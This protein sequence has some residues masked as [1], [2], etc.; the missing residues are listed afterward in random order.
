MRLHC[1]S[2]Y[3]ALMAATLIAADTPTT[4]RTIDPAKLT[5]GGFLAS[6]RADM[7]AII[8]WL[9]GHRAGAFDEH[10]QNL[11]GAATE[12]YRRVALEQEPLRRRKPVRTKR[13]RRLVA[14]CCL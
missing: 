13:D 3:P 4:I 1:G 11:K 12:P 7:A 6:D 10:G 2:L 14:R 9:L 8:M 5:C